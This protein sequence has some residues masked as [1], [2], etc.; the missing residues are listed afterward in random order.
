MNKTFSPS[1]DPDLY[2][3]RKSFEEVIELYNMKFFDDDYIED[4]VEYR[5]WPFVF[6]CFDLTEIRARS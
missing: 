1:T 6:K 2:W 3:A 5:I 4:D